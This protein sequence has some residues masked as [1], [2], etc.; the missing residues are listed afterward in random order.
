MPPKCGVGLRVSN[1]S[2]G[3]LD[4]AGVNAE[5]LPTAVV[6]DKRIADG[7]QGYSAS[8]EREAGLGAVTTLDDYRAGVAAAIKGGQAIPQLSANLV[9]LARQHQRAQAKV[10]SFSSNAKPKPVGIWNPYRWL[11][12]G[13]FTA[14]SAWRTGK[15]SEA[16]VQLADV[17]VRLRLFRLDVRCFDYRPPLLNIVL[18]K[19]PYPFRRALLVRWDFQTQFGEQ[20]AYLR[21]DESLDDRA[22]EL[23]DDV[24]ARVPPIIAASGRPRRPFFCRVTSLPARGSAGPWGRTESF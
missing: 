2:R 17:K 8:I 21:I 22:V 6:I 10:K 5:I 9:K 18:V 3:T 16:L 4:K 14:G 1:R 23:S 12:P 19:C 24:V 20:S 15:S 13:R 7:E 11:E